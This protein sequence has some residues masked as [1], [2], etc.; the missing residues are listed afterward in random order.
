MCT[1]LPGRMRRQPIAPVSRLPAIIAVDCY[2]AGWQV[3]MMERR[4]IESREA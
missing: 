4:Q 3:F 2:P 1:V